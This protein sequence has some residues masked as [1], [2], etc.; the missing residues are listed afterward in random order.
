[1]NDGRTEGR[2]TFEAMNSPCEIPYSPAPPDSDPL[3]LGSYTESSLPPKTKRTLLPSIHSIPMIPDSTSTSTTCG[4]RTPPRAQRASDR[5]SEVMRARVSCAESAGCRYFFGN[6]CLSR[7]GLPDAASSSVRYALYTFCAC[8]NRSCV[9]NRSQK[10]DTHRF[11]ALRDKL[12]GLECPPQGHRAVV[13]LRLFASRLINRP[14]TNR[15]SAYD[16]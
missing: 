7:T 11:S 14:S 12:C 2:R 15:P 1:M 8:I 5:A 3:P 10:S 4:T 13:S 6:R 9:S 16:A